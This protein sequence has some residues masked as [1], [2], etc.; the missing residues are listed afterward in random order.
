MS[1]STR[2]TRAFTLIEL[3]V[4]IAIIAILAAILFPVFAQAREKARATSCLSNQKQLGLAFMQYIQDY[5]EMLPLAVGSAVV[6][7][8]TVATSW[9]VDLIGGTN[10][11]TAIVPAGGSAPG[12]LSPYMKNNQIVVCPSA[13]GRPNANSAALGYMYNDLVVAQSQA[14]FAAVAQTV[15]VAESSSA[16]GAMLGTAVPLR[17]NVGH[18]INRPAGSFP[19][20]AAPAALPTTLAT[21]PPTQPVTT[22][23]LDQASVAD[24]TRHSGGGNFLYAD[25]H[26]KWAKVTTNAAGV[27]ATIYFPPATVARPTAANNGGTLV[28]E[29][30]NEPQPGGN[31]LGYAGT[32]FLN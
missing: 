14:S 26:A 3:L 6:G 20:V 11:S 12:L 5:D 16:S 8:T 19:G 31:M 10:V 18:A 30:T 22:L 27:P 24:I 25:G 28:V 1:V 7:S 4:V 9:A 2:P 13:S 29:G 32:M 23:P 21:I 17:L 15:I